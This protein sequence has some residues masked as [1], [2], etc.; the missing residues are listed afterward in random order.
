MSTVALAWVCNEARPQDHADFRLLTLLADVAGPDGTGAYP[1]Q[2]TLAAGMMRSARMVRRGLDALLAKGFIRR[3]DQSRAGHLPREQRPIVY[4]LVMDRTPTP[5][6]PKSGPEAAAKTPREAPKHWRG[7]AGTAPETATPPDMPC[8]QGDLT[9]GHAVSTPAD[10]PPDMPCPGGDPKFRT[11]RVLQT[12]NITT[13]QQNPPTPQ[14]ADTAVAIIDTPDAPTALDSAVAPTDRVA[15][16]KAIVEQYRTSPMCPS[17]KLPTSV[18]AGITNATLEL[19][20][21]GYT[22][23]QLA[24]GISAWSKAGMVSPTQIANFVNRVANQPADDFGHLP[25]ASAKAASWLAL[26]GERRTVAAYG[27]A[28]ALIDADLADFGAV[29]HRTKELA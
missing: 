14:T 21:D 18:R 19:L 13:K 3:G 25:P 27:N 1:S 16:A 11:R 24:D 22:V 15:A 7:E 10:V 23:R 17:G 2:A 29:T 26:A 9:S 12:K 5:P 20:K 28:Q 4:D 8:P 6:A